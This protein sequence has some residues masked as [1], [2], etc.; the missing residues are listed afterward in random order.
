MTHAVPEAA[1]PFP[2]ALE[3]MSSV[4]EVVA[5]P[6]A[7]DV[8]R[9]SR[10]P[11]EALA[12]MRS[13]GLLSMMV[14]AELGGESASLAA[15]GEA[16]TEISRACASTGM[17]FAMHQIQ[18]ACLVR[19][20]RPQ[21]DGFL[22]EEV[23]GRQALLAS[24][25]TELGV[26]GDVRT[27]LCAVAEEGG[28]YS[29]RKH[30]PV[31]SY[32]QHADAILATARRTPESPPNDQV[33]VMCRPPGV[34]LEP[35]SGWDTAGFRGTCSL[36][37][38][39][40]AEGPIDDVLP[41]AYSDISS[42]TMLPVSHILW[43]HVWL[44]IADEAASRARAFVRAEAR[45][46]PGVTPPAAVHLAELMTVHL[47]LESLCRQSA[48]RFD[49]IDPDS[50]DAESM[51]YAVAMNSLKVA[52][53]T[54]VVDIVTRAMRICGMAGYREDSA[55][56]MGRLLRDA[57]GAALMVNNDRILANSAQLLLVGRDR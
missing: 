15:V 16:V 33:L 40:S 14:P 37:F 51:A 30:A 22:R 11:S 49:A 3:R 47:Q 19:H 57:H 4:A 54:L 17:I 26:G 18:L 32:G 34:V 8:D 21:F 44:G 25:T 29:L 23:V 20:G 46:K 42:R 43:S 6:V 53:S 12:A 35:A 55:F 13:Q 39:L 52:A 38:V 7:A 10:F 27:S 9:A 36:G 1:G 28:R 31:I 41:V 56:S 45:K 5:G 48:Q 2:T 24:A 50:E